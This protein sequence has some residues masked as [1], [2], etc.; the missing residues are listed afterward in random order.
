MIKSHLLSFVY[1]YIRYLCTRQSH[2][3]V[4]VVFMYCQSVYIYIHD[5]NIM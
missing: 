5:A 1:Y 4:F 2:N 3:Q